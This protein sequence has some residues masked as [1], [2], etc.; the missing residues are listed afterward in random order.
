MNTTSEKIKEEILRLPSDELKKF[1][2][3]YERFDSDEWDRQIERDVSGGKLDA[4][5]D[6]ALSDHAEGK[7]RKL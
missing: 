2:A 7:S 1:R 6:V 4:L 5:A 3:W